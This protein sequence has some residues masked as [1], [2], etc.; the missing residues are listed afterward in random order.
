[1]RKVFRQISEWGVTLETPAEKAHHLRLTNILL[2]F[3]FFASIIQTGILFL[4]GAFEAAIL[5]STAPFVFA[6]GLIFMKIGYT[7]VARLFV[8]SISFVFGY[9]VAAALGPDSYFQFIFLFASAFAI[10]FFS[11]TEKSL[12][13]LGVFAPIIILTLLEMTNYQPIL[14]MSR[15]NLSRDHLGIMRMG[16]MIVIW[17]IM[18]FHFI[19]FVRGRKKLQEQLVSSAKMVGMG[20]MAAGI[21]HEVN[22]PLQLIVSRAERVKALTLQPQINTF[23]VAKDADQILLVAMR[24]ASIVKGLLALSRDAS[25]DDMRPVQVQSVLNSS[26]DFC[27]ARL[28]SKN[29]D[30]K[31]CSIPLDWSVRGRP[32]QLSEV[33]LNVLNNSF[34]AVMEAEEKWVEIRAAADDQWIELSVLDSGGGVDPVVQHK[35]FDPFFT[36]KPVGQGTG[37][38]LSVSQGIVSGHGGQIFLDDSSPCTR[39]VIRLPRSNEAVS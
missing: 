31:V 1:M 37:L 27:R 36:T 21:A 26:L 4:S 10:V 39:F 2:L 13:V 32:T 20:R 16:T 15:A 30:F 18:I 11:A 12:L 38:G 34:D 8:L 28:E 25:R 33:L 14:G 29:I 19:Y 3:M 5:N 7:S 9:A 35:I 24:I 22:N 17:G 6:T 23:E